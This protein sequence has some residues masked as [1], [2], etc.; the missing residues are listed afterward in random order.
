M[1]YPVDYRGVLATTVPTPDWVGPEGMVSLV[2]AGMNGVYM[3]GLHRRVV[4]PDPVAPANLLSPS[5]TF[6][7][8]A[9]LRI[10]CAASNL[11]VASVALVE[12]ARVS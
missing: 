4:E 10:H 1:Y 12:A 8:Q 7:A 6:Q 2:Y 3:R 11:G 5:P 9:A